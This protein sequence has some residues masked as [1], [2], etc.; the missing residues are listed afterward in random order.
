MSGFGSDGTSVMIGHK[1]AASKFK[2]NNA[3]EISIHCHN[4]RL[5][6]TISDEPKE[7]FMTKIEFWQ[8]F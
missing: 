3:K 7:V 2:R 1:A 6:L 8:S 4:Q 5:A